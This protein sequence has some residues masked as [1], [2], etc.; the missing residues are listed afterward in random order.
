MQ[1][2]GGEGC[3][4]N[5][6]CGWLQIRLGDFNAEGQN[7][8]LLFV[9]CEEA[10]QRDAHFTAAVAGPRWS[11]GRSQ[12]PFETWEWEWESP[13]GK[14]GG[15]EKRHALGI[16]QHSGQRLLAGRPHCSGDVCLILGA[17]LE[18]AGHAQL[19]DGDQHLQVWEQPHLS[20]R[21]AQWRKFLCQFHFKWE[22]RP[23]RNNMADP[24]SKSPALLGT[25]TR[26]GYRTLQT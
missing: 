21:Q 26:S 3:W 8:D 5:M 13:G 2:G 18:H 22:Y 19:N 12:W 7:F 16:V 24:V 9:T 1:R 23:G 10:Q 25:L 17:P 6:K 20:R 14:G 4:Q 15:V 11:D